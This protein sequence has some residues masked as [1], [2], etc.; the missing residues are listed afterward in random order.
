MKRARRRPPALTRPVAKP[1]YSLAQLLLDMPEGPPIL[2]EWDTMPPV[3]REV[4]PGPATLCT[5]RATRR[6]LREL[7]RKRAARGLK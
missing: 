5:I 4:E 3:G 7:K 6:F 2:R 1:R